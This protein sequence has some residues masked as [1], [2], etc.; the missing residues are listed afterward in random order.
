MTEPRIHMR[1]ARALRGRGKVT[2]TPGI[3]AWISLHGIDIRKFAAE[4]VAGEEALRIG[5]AFA[6]KLLDIARKEAT[7]NGR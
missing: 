5:D 1:H 2:C 4:G 3:R 7:G 6:L